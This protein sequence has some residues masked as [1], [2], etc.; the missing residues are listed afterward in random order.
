MF[1]GDTLFTTASSGVT[2][3]TELGVEGGEAP[4][5][6]FTGGSNGLRFFCEMSVSAATAIIEVV[7]TRA[8]TALDVTMG[9]AT[10]EGTEI[11]VYADRASVTQLTTARR[12][13]LANGAGNYL[14]Q[15]VFNV[16]NRDTFDL[17]GHHKGTASVTKVKVGC[18]QL[19]S[20][21]L[22][23]RGMAFRAI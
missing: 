4:T 2:T 20:G 16:T 6:S 5:G 3:Y 9:A 7:L 11:V 18:I 10:V 21:N 13:Q 15:V 22:R 19:S 17:M 23:V 14:C 12:N 1:I 8:A